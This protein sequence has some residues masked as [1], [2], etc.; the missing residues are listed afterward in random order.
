MGEQSDRDRQPSARY[1]ERLADRLADKLMEDLR[2][3]SIEVPESM[4]PMLRRELWWSILGV[5]KEL[6]AENEQRD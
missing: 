1:V 5:A 4:A 2:L 3:F 6:R